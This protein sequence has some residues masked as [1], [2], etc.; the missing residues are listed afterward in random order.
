VLAEDR[1]VLVAPRTE[2]IAEGI[3]GVLGD[4]IRARR[5][6]AAARSYAQKHLGWN[7]FVESVEALYAEVGRDATVA[8][9]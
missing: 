6:A 5:L 1:A 8:R 3:L 4:D 9:A 2:A 7:R